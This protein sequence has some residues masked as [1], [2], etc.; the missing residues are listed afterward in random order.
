MVEN[1]QDKSEEW[2]T[3]EHHVRQIAERV[4]L[5][6]APFCSVLT[7]FPWLALYPTFEGS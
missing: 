6:K 7:P 4:V 5:I 3:A 2:D 1:L